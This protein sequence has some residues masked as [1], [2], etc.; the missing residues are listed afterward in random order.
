VSRRD[1][2]V[3]ELDLRVWQEWV[4]SLLP[5]VG[6]PGYTVTRD[7]LTTQLART[8]SRVAAAVA[9]AL[10]DGEQV[11]IEAMLAPLD[12]RAA[13]RMML[14]CVHRVITGAIETAQYL[15]GLWSQYADEAEARLPTE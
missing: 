9:L 1:P 5:P 6:T 12:P 7:M 15:A 3:T 13:V 4:D 10:S 11:H 8:E 14:G 2:D